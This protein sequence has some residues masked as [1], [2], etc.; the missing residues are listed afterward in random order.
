MREWNSLPQVSL[1]LNFLEFLGIPETDLQIY[2]LT[3]TSSYTCTKI[4]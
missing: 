3:E 4:F 1:K 2:C